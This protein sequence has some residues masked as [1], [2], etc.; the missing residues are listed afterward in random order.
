MK[1]A[2]I[3]SSRNGDKYYIENSISSGSYGTT[4]TVYK[5]VDNG[6]VNEINEGSR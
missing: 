3:S 1:R 4:F 5:V 6:E 2:Y